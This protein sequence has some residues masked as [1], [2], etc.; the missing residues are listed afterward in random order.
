MT[1]RI[2]TKIDFE[3]YEQLLADNQDG[4]SRHLD[5]NDYIWKINFNT[6]PEVETLEKRNE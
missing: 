6:S 1:N 5:Y 3:S 4:F 2:W